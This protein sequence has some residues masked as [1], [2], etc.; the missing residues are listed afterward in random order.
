M[1]TRNLE[2]EVID[3]SFSNVI[4]ERLFLKKNFRVLIFFFS[5]MGIK[6][7]VIIKIKW[8]EVC[9]RILFF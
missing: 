9:E 1:K 5:K 2:L 6:I 7:L 3:M 8:C 4:L